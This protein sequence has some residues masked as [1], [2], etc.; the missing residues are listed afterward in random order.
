MLPAGPLVT[1]S[2][3]KYPVCIDEESDLDT[4]DPGR[5]ELYRPQFE[6]RQASAILSKLTLSLQNM[7][8]YVC[9][10]IHSRGKTFRDAGR[11]SRIAV[12]Q[13]L[14]NAAH[15]LDSERQRHY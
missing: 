2:D 4:R 15:S 10:V 3:I 1:R 14:H 6:A 5:L 8:V 9:L 13:A 12:D 11:D 7:Y